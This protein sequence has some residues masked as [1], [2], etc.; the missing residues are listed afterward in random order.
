MKKWLFILAGLAFAGLLTGGCGAG[1][2]V[3]PSDANRGFIYGYINTPNGSPDRIFLWK[4]GKVYAPPF[5]PFPK[6]TV[7]DDGRFFAE[8]MEP[9]DYYLYSFWL[10]RTAYQVTT[11]ENINSAVFT[12]RPGAMLYIGSYEVGEETKGDMLSSGKFTFQAVTQPSAAAILYKYFKDPLL[13]GTGWDDRIR[14]E[15]SRLTQR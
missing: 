2:A 9:G 14:G 5:S 4:K 8:N 12:L 13:A 10:G 1:R 3:P 7:N 15:Y 6:V 11:P